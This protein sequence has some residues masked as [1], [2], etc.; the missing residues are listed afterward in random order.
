M[1][2]WRKKEREALKDKH[3][4]LVLHLWFI[5][6]LNKKEIQNLRFVRSVVQQQQTHITLF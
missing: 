1:N 3:L 2:I 5:G 6:P 4:R